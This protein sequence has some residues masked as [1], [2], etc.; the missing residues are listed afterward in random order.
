MRQL[1]SIL[2]ISLFIFGSCS[3]GRVI[4]FTNSEAEFSTY[5]TYK[6]RRIKQDS[7][8]T[9]GIKILETIKDAIQAEMN[10]RGYKPNNK[11]DLQLHYDL[12]SSLESSGPPANTYNPYFFNPYAPA[13]MPRDI[14]KSVLLIEIYDLK[15]K[16]L[17]WQASLDLSHV[18]REKKRSE[19]LQK[20]VARIFSTY[21][22]TAPN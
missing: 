4:H 1:I 5:K 22:Q 3:G 21:L 14:Y 17:V 18:K 11:A 6:F 10:L 2:F 15:N 8:S 7:I 9:D 16:K 12:I 20:A 13:F 19:M